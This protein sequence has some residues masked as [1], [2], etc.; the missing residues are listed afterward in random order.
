MLLQA[1]ATEEGSKLKLLM[2]M[3]TTQICH[4][5]KRGRRK[6]SKIRRGGKS[7][8][9]LL[10]AHGTGLRVKLPSHNAPGKGPNSYESLVN[11]ANFGDKM[12]PRAKEKI[13]RVSVSGASGSCY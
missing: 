12:F 8:W 7:E 5:C 10:Q 3:P 1:H 9:A 11:Y 6:V 13:K 4:I 2:E